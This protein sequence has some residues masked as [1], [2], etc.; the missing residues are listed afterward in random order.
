MASRIKG[1]TVEIGGDTTGLDKALRGVNSTITKTQSSLKDVSR[2]LKLDPGNTELL[3]QKQKLLSQAIG[4]TKTKLDTLKTA[5]E[6]ATASVAKYDAWKAKYDPIQSEIT[7]TETKLKSLKEKAADA[8]AQFQAGKIDK[9]TY[10]GI[11]SE[12]TETENKLKSLKEQA[13]SVNDEFGNPVSPEQYDALQREIIETEHDLKKLE[14]QAAKSST[15]LEKIA[16]SGEKLKKVG[17]A[18]SGVGDKLTLGVTTPLVA[19]GTAGVNSFAEVDKTMA[20]ANKTMGNTAEEAA[21]VDEAMTSAASNSTFGVS[22]ASTA[23]LNFA[24]AGLKAEEASNALA[25]AMNLAAGEGGDLDTVSAGL[26]ATING[27][28]GSFSEAGHYTDVFAAACNNSALD[29]NTLSESMSTAAPIFNSAG[30]SVE[31]ATLA[32]G[33]MGNAGIDA[34]TAANSLKTGLAR[35]VSPAKEGAEALESLGF[36]AGSAQDNTEKLE[37]A[38]TTLKEATVTCEAKQASYNEKV[39]KYGENSSQALNALAALT[40]AQDKQASAQRAVNIL[41]EA[42]N[43]DM[44]SYGALMVDAEGNMRPFEDVLSDLQTAFGGLSSEQQIAAASAIFGKNQMTSWL[45]LIQ[46][47]PDKVSALSNSIH[48]CDDTTQEMAETMMNGFGGSIESVKSSLD[49][50]IYKLGQTLA[51][52]IQKVIN[53]VQELVDKFNALSPAQQDTVVK[54]GMVVAAIGPLLSVVGRALVATGNV[55]TALPKVKGLLVG[56]GGGL[57]AL[58]GIVAANPIVAIIAL[59][60][61][62][63]AA[64]VVLYKKNETFRNFINGM[65]AGIKQVV[66]DVVSAIAGFFTETLPAAFDGFVSFFEGIWNGISSFFSSIWEGIQSVASSAAESVKSAI[67]TAWNSIKAVT[68]TIWNGIKSVVSTV[69]DGIKSVVSG[70]VNAMKTAVSTAWNAIKTTTSTIWNGIKTVINTVWTGIKTVVTTAVNAIKTVVT[71]IWNAIKTVITTV[72]NGIKTTVS[73]IWNGIKT[74]ISTVMNG[75]KSTVSSIWNAIKSTVS[76]VVNGIK[77]TVTS[78]WNGIKSSVSSVMNGISSAVS[79]G[80]NT[81][82]NSVV[83]ICNGIKSS[84]SSIWNGIKST[85][86]SVVS[87]ILSTIS[88]GFGAAK[89]TAISIFNGIKSGISG[90]INGAKNAVSTAIN[91]I[92]GA[93][94]FSWSLPHLKLPHISIS[95]SFSI[96][97]PSVP[98]FSI[99]WY[100][101]AMEGGMIL[102]SP[103]IFGMQGGKLLAGGEA[104]SETVVG[105]AS[106]M[107]MIQSAVTKTGQAAQNINYGGVTMNIYGAQGQSV[108]ELADIIEERINSGVIKKGAVFA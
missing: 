1:I 18:V 61:A 100:K 3:N 101:K 103:T 28:H 74:T 63:V 30:Y 86:S 69:W 49:V 79:S 93:F 71:T 44:A 4:E 21:K 45:A 42:G 32:L 83:N 22:D 50:L 15:A 36:S 12:V 10:D 85:V 62:V 14:T 73:M 17:S 75:I 96:N 90:A 7:E 107:E 88:S 99:S 98:H 77:S 26:V 20:L 58:W 67:S 91:A 8:D 97:P 59:I 81:A 47:S 84:V 64:L 65:W 25:P 46:T 102:N 55:M 80:W 60:A 38:Q 92:K 37:K 95:G 94:N 78:V 39:A 108:T 68:S 66:S 41:T 11:Q 82:K 57:K 31:D 23:M 70:A 72:L 104:G 29:V 54:I 16:A 13:K 52:Y 27:F 51:P 87:G 19:A 105:T 40:K 34:N 24:R 56:V 2:L 33:L 5:N 89:N 48:N 43:G 53:A 106:L 35:L 6:Q 76:S 9:A